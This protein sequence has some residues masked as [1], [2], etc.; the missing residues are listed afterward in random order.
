VGTSADGR[1]RITA[2]PDLIDD[3]DCTVLHVDMDAFFASVELRRRP[4]LRGRP[5][6]VAGSGPRSVVLSATYEARRFG[7]RSAM[8]VGRAK[9]LCPGIAVVDPDPPAYRAASAAVMALFGDVTP[10]VEQVSVDEAFLDVAGAGRVAGRPGRIAQDLRDRIRAELGLPAT[11]GASTTKFV[12]KL[13]SSLAKPNGLL[14]VPQTDVLPLLHPLPVRALWG[15]GPR[16][17]ERLTEF[18]LSTVG[19][20]A[21]AGRTTLVRLLGN[22][23]GSS[24]HELAWGRDPRPVEPESS[25]ASIGAETTFDVD[26]TDRVAQRRELLALADRSCRRARAAG[27]RGR[28]V[29]IKVRFADFTTVTRSVTLDTATSLTRTVHGSAIALFDRLGVGSRSIRLIGVRL[30]HLVPAGEV[31]EQLTFDPEPA[32]PGWAEAESAVDRIAARFGPAAVRPAV[33][34]GR[35]DRSPRPDPNPGGGDET[36]SRG[37]DRISGGPEPLSAGPEPLS[38][39]PNL[40]SGPARR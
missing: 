30:E 11:V 31:T 38:E 17:A 2:D 6:M 5:M 25:E 19:D 16:A 32:G 28:T 27:L 39:A 33:L 21:R 1:R 12:A 34:V 40:K 7:L 24:I 15:V 26:S 35:P 22:A 23:A 3:R 10:L 36:P 4:D 20:V 37:G 9:A 14:L 13:A 18:G 8:P 29:S